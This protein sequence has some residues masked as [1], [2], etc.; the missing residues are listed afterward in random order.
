MADN[1]SNWY[2]QGTHDDRWDDSELRT[3]KK[4]KGSD[5]EAVDISP[6]MERPGFNPNSATVPQIS[7]I[8]T[9]VSSSLRKQEFSLQQKAIN[10]RNS[11]QIRYFLKKTVM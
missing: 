4:L 1:G 7:P 2:F 8:R 3:L 5:F 6:W 11:F 10:G 9:P